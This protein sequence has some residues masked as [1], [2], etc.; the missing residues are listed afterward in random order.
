M[1]KSCEH[2]SHFWTLFLSD[3]RCFSGLTWYISF[4]IL[5]V[6]TDDLLVVF[7]RVRTW[8]VHI[9]RI[10]GSNWHKSF[11][12]C[13]YAWQEFAGFTHLMVAR[14]GKICI[15][16][17]LRQ[18]KICY[19]DLNKKFFL[20]DFILEIRYY[21]QLILHFKS[22]GRFIID[23]LICNFELNFLVCPLFFWGG[24]LLE[25][26]P[27]LVGSMKSFAYQSKY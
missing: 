14:A 24:G 13:T 23:T 26:L 11:C 2:D 19:L 27:D 4:G 10:G 12:A 15:S 8:L 1:I 6:W 7:L 20:L 9:L 25:G 5:I 3:W 18:K 17:F 16:Y 21:F 22:Q